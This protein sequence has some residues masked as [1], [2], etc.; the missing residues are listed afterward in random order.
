MNNLKIFLCIENSY[1]RCRPV[2]FLFALDFIS[3]SFADEPNSLRLFCINYE[4]MRGKLHECGCLSFQ[5]SSFSLSMKGAWHLFLPSY[6]AITILMGGVSVA[7]VVFA[8]VSTIVQ[9][10]VTFQ[11]LAVGFNE[12]LMQWVFQFLRR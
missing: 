1:P 11:S 4:K 3:H 5:F 8:L 7:S 10:P 9:L 6:L 12:T 2:F